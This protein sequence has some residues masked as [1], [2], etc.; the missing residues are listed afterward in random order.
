MRKLNQIIVQA[1]GRVYRDMVP[2]TLFSLIS[3]LFLVPI[4][5]FL[6]LPVALLLLPFVYMPAVYGVFYAVYRMLKDGRAKA[7]DVLAG[8]VKGYIPATVFGIV[9]TLFVLILVSTWWYYGN[10]EGMLYKTVA[11]FQTYFVAM[12]FVSQIYTLPL[13]IQEKMGIFSAMGRSVK[14]FVTHPGYTIGAFL[15]AACLTVVLLVTVVG[16]AALFNGIMGIYAHMVTRN[17][18]QGK[19]PESSGESTGAEG[20]GSVN[21][22]T[23]G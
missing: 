16:Y 15:Q 17:L 4:V 18:L 20:G 12:V 14:L 22:F 5:F 23:W 11:I 6:P 3:S 13:V 19:N 7:R 8:A 2:V 9:C 10:K 21:G 1:A